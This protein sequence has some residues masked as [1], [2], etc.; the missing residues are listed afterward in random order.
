MGHVYVLIVM[1]TEV[2]TPLVNTRWLLDKSGLK[3]SIIYIVNGITMMVVWFLDRILFLG[4][5]YFPLIYRHRDELAM[6]NDVY[7]VLLLSIPPLLSVLNVFWFG[8]M[9]KG[10]IKVLKKKKKS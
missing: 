1:S 9:V 8:K 10:A 2:T 7:R 4:C 6:L 3:Q 5:Y